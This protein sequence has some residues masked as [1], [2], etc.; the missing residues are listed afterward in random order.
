MLT[1]LLWGGSF[2][3]GIAW[4]WRSP[5]TAAPWNKRIFNFYFHFFAPVV[6]LFAYT[7]VPA[8]ATTLI[9]LGAVILASYIVLAI[10]LIYARLAARDRG[11]QGV[12][13]LGSGFTN[14]VTLGYPVINAV[15]GPA[16]LALQVLF[17]QF[18]YLIPIVS[19]STTIAAHYGN[20]TRPRG[21]GGIARQIINVPLIF[22]VIAVVIRVA[23][24]KLGLGI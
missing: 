5:H 22:A 16:G 19:V 10:G 13:A 3:A 4:Q 20:G 8:D 2:A 15:F 18:M 12:L 9:G 23:G 24:F 6:V 21:W 11:E 14:T 17:A 7:V 1:A